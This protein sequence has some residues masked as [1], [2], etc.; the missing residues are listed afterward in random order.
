MGIPE[1]LCVGRVTVQFLRFFILLHNT[2]G[3]LWYIN[4]VVIMKIQLLKN[5]RSLFLLLCLSFMMNALLLFGLYI[6]EKHSC[7][8]SLAL[9]RRGYIVVDDEKLPDSWARKCWVNTVKKLYTEFDVAFFGNSIVTG[10][11]FQMKFPDKKIINLGYSGDNMIGMLRRVPMLKA[12]NPKKIFIMAG[13]NDL[14]HIGL[15]EYEKRYE[16]LLRT[17]KDALPNA[18][19]YIQS[20]LPSNHKMIDY[21]PNEK[22]QKANGIAKEMAA[23]FQC[24]YIHLYD[25]YV[26]ENNELPKELTRDGVHLHKNAYDRWAEAIRPL[27]YE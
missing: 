25:L 24:S 20:V 22:V 21:A 14:V 13:T 1:P 15:E 6:L 18:R 7:V 10:S 16:N 8:L 23:V 5:H 26:D 19:I 2:V 11:D 27:V 9:E 17:I 3:E 4:I 12:A